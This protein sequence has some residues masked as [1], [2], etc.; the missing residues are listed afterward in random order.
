MY[1]LVNLLGMIGVLLGMVSTVYV[2][3]HPRA[4]G[5]PFSREQKLMMIPLFLSICCVVTAAFLW[6]TRR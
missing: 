2:A 5:E 3:K 4:E 1:Y 6:F